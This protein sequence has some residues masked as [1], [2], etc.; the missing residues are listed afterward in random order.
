MDHAFSTLRGRVHAYSHDLASYFKDCIRKPRDAHGTGCSRKHAPTT[1]PKLWKSI[2]IIR[3]RIRR[4]K[5]IIAE[6]KQIYP[7]PSRPE[8]GESTRG[9]AQRKVRIRRNQDTLNAL[10]EEYQKLTAV[11]RSIRKWDRVELPKVKLTYKA[12]HKALGPQLGPFNK[13]NIAWNSIVEN[14]QLP[15]YTVHA[16]QIVPA[17]EEGS[18]EGDQSLQDSQNSR[19]ADSQTGEEPQQDPPDLEPAS[20]GDIAVGNANNSRHV[21]Q[22]PGASEKA[23]DDFIFSTKV[24]Y[25]TDAERKKMIQYALKCAKHHDAGWAKRREMETFVEELKG[26]R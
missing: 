16:T 19:M 23:F 7:T 6:M 20:G 18:N 26:R 17:R 11:Q 14:Y 10:E 1:K 21:Q 12:L 13:P 15:D 2:C 9:I 22:S 5:M 4:L 8:L 25:F 3:Q 24:Y